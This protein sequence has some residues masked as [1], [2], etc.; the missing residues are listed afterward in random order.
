MILTVA[1]AGELLSAQ[2]RGRLAAA[3]AV[4][5]AYRALLG[6]KKVC[7]CGCGRVFEPKRLTQRAATE[8]CGRRID[9]ANHCTGKPRGRPARK[10]AQ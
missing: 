10:P 2:M 7:A 3:R 5:R 6:H 4:G 9:N 1:L 8:E